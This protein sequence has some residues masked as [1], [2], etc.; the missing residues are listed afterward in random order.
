MNSEW[1]IM[2]SKLKNVPERDISQFTIHYLLLH[3][4]T[5]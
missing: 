4:V 3:L 2:N 5:R 1:Q